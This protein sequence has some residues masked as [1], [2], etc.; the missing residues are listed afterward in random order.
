MYTYVEQKQI[1]KKTSVI[2]QLSTLFAT[3]RIFCNWDLKTNL[4]LLKY[5]LIFD[6]Y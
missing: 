1:L 2:L 4:L 5:H 6:L 3:A